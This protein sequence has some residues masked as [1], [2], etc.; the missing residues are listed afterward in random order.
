MTSDVKYVAIIV[1]DFSYRSLNYDNVTVY[2]YG[3]E[4]S[5][6]FYDSYYYNYW[7][8]MDPYDY[9]DVDWNETNWQN[10]GYYNLNQFY[11]PEVVD[12]GIIGPTL[13]DYNYLYDLYMYEG[14]TEYSTFQS[15]LHYEANPTAPYEPGHGDWV[16]ES[17]FQQLDDPDSVEIIAIDV[18]FTSFF[19]FGALFEVTNGFSG[20]QWIVTNAIDDFYEAGNEYV[21]TGLSA[22]FGSHIVSHQLAMLEGL[23][24]DW[25]AIVVQ[26]VANVGQYSIPWG[27]VQAGVVNVGAYNVDPNG[28]I[29]FGDD[30][31]ATAT[32]ILANGYVESPDG[33]GSNFGTSFATPRV[34]AE[35]VNLFDSTLSPSLLSGEVVLP[36][37]TEMERLTDSEVT[38][39]SNNLVGE[40]SRAIT[41]SLN[42]I[43]RTL[44]VLSDD[45]KS[46]PYPKVLP[47]DASSTG[48][49]LTSAAYPLPDLLNLTS[50]LSV[51]VDAGVLGDTAIYLNGLSETKITEDGILISHTIEYNGT[52]FNYSDIDHLFMTV[53]SDGNFTNEFQIE[54]HDFAPE[55]SEVTYAEA[56][57]L[58]G[59]NNFESVVLSVAGAD[60]NFIS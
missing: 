26:A 50:Q 15:L 27:N 2:D 60:G 35:I 25:G 16:L 39:A 45:V 19:D 36:R 12:N 21:L 8:S 32:D 51:V 13:L 48:V 18:D 57:G 56:V 23:V 7:Y 17:F 59:L 42:G 9:G 33:W 24:N 30:S 49:V 46:S 22:S 41:A 29:L 11:D 34:F 53:L 31:G 6:S 43:D 28:Y 54:I 10:Y 44:F 14:Y 38:E 4:T 55:Y 1:D 52:V 58:V 40:I 20:L 47:Y 37:I 5:A 3:V